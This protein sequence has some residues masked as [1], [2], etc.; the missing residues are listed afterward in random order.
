MRARMCFAILSF[1]STSIADRGCPLSLGFGTRKT[2]TLEKNPQVTLKEHV[3]KNKFRYF[4]PLKMC[5]LFNHSIIWPILTDT[6][7]DYWLE[8]SN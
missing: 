6:N 8:A 1:R 7:A 5:L 3:A 4:L 2:I